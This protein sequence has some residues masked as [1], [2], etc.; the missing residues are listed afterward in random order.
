MA[1]VNSDAIGIRAHQVALLW[2][3]QRT[4]QARSSRTEHWTGTDFETDIV[5]AKTLD[6]CVLA[7]VETSETR[8]GGFQL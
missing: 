6:C 2:K 1:L 8:R 4:L 5:H 7:E 3:T